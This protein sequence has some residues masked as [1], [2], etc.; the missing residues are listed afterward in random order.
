MLSLC[1]SCGI[2]APGPD[3][4]CVVC[5]SPSGGRPL[6]APERPDGTCWACIWGQFTCR[7][8][9][10]QSPIN[11]LDADGG[12]QCVHCGIDQAFD[13]SRWPGVLALAHDV[14]DYEGPSPQYRATDPSLPLTLDL[15]EWRH[16]ARH[17]QCYTWT[18]AEDSMSLV[19][20]WAV[21]PGHP[22]CRSCGALLESGFDIQHRLVTSCPGCGDRSTYDLGSAVVRLYRPLAGVV[23]DEHRVDLPLARPREDRQSQAVAIEC[24]LCR[25]PLAVGADAPPIVSCEHC[26]ASVRVPSEIRRGADVEG[27]G[28][29]PFWLLFEGISRARA[30]AEEGARAFLEHE[31][32]RRAHRN[33]ERQQREERLAKGCPG[34]GEYPYDAARGCPVCLH[35][36]PWPLRHPVAMGLISW[37]VSTAVTGA[38][39]LI[40]GP[41]FLLA[42][43]LVLLAAGGAL[44]GYGVHLALVGKEKV[45]VA[46]SE[47]SGQ[48][49]F[50]FEVRRPLPGV[51]TAS[52][53]VLMLAAAIYLATV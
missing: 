5:C 19:L 7:S 8:C 18:D 22:V 41:P 43:C 53:G 49:S 36:K 4:G 2:R 38:A 34:C 52:V 42:L 14:A 1:S 28:I 26:G 21:A 12:L 40:A 6:P 27:T 45:M 29:V 31:A 37:L 9:G 30:E 15:G 10:F 25:A 48:E 46:A 3:V 33:R 44:L 35:G 51:V 20:E 23:A 32:E 24:P 17:P 11:F 50:L 16:I 13:V 47:R 39:V